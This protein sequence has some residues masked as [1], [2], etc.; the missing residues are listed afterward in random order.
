M[1]KL[2]AT[3]IFCVSAAS[4]SA[5]STSLATDAGNTPPETSASIPAPLEPEM[6]W[7]TV[8]QSLV[9]SLL[10]YCTSLDSWADVE[11]S[12]NVITPE[13]LPDGSYHLEAYVGQGSIGLSAL[14]T[15]GKVLIRPFNTLGEVALDAWGCPTE[16][17]ATFGDVWNMTGE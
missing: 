6:P 17:N 1:R 9:G 3:V 8:K 15:Q 7:P 5:C 4:L 10:S 12:W 2:L 14:A 16:I 11:G 13:A